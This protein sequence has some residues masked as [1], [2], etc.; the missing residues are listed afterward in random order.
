MQRRKIGIIAIVLLCAAALLPLWPD[1]SAA[2]W[3]AQAAC[4][5]IGLIMGA[6]WLAYDELQR[7]PK[8][9]AVAIPAAI[10]L[11]AANKRFFPIALILIIVAVVVKLGRFT[12]KRDKPPP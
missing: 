1:R 12:R 3:Q 2:L 7:V 11:A 5:R 6:W 10:L 9:L 8:W 4:L